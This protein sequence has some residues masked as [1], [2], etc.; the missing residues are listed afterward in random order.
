MPPCRLP[1]SL[2]PF[3]PTHVRTRLDAV[4]LLVIAVLHRVC[5]CR[6]SNAAPKAVVLIAGQCSRRSDR[7][8]ALESHVSARLHCILQLRTAL[9]ARYAPH[10]VVVH[11]IMLSSPYLIVICYAIRHCLSKHSLTSL[12]STSSSLLLLPRF[13]LTRQ[14][15]PKQRR[16]APA[17]SRREVEERYIFLHAAPI[18]YGYF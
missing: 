4:L 13:N 1:A 15:R 14:L 10:A 12:A 17:V 2:L 9:T 16:L 6:R 8:I 11:S 7:V 18:V 3:S 5:T